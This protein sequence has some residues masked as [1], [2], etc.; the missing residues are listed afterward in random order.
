[1]NPPDPGVPSEI[2]SL[3]FNATG[4]VEGDITGEAEA[5]AGC[6]AEAA[7]GDTVAAVGP[8]WHAPTRRAIA[9]LPTERGFI[10]L[11]V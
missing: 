1:M 2:G 6:D 7:D 3:Q 4:E 10:T 11:L 8:D 5:A 9:K